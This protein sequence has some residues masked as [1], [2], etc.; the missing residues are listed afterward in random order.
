MPFTSSTGKWNSRVRSSPW[1]WV[2]KVSVGVS[3]F[4]QKTGVKRSSF[5]SF[6]SVIDTP[7]H[8]SF[9]YD[10]LWPIT[11]L[12]TVRDSVRYLDEKGNG[13]QGRN[14]KFFEDYNT[15]I[16]T[17]Y[18]QKIFFKQNQKEHF[19]FHL[20]CLSFIHSVRRF[21]TATCP[22]FHSIKNSCLLF[23]TMLDLP[24]K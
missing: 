15:F 13:S 17:F 5:R 20:R 1:S 19:W 9:V 8:G 24:K 7:V 18:F 6:M 12:L 16:C 4:E 3:V 22:F 2:V 23:P 10:F 21:F 14:A 11:P